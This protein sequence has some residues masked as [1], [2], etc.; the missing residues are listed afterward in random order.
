[1][2]HQCEGWFNSYFRSCAG[3]RSI[4]GKICNE[5]LEACI[6]APGTSVFCLH[7]R[8]RHLPLR[9]V[10]ISVLANSIILPSS[11][12]THLDDYDTGFGDLYTNHFIGPFVIS[13]D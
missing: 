12:Q 4:L 6:A 10:R 7:W 1:M 9:V 2:I 3:C 8:D 13:A 11:L 5:Q